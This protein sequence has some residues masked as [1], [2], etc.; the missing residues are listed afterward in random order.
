M[1]TPPAVFRS[2]LRLSYPLAMDLS[3]V[4]PSS[5][6]PLCSIDFALAIA[7]ARCGASLAFT[8]KSI[9]TG[10]SDLSS[11]LLKRITSF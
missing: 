11:L 8:K 9:A 10:F 3:Y 4:R 5:C 1:Y 7:C 2:C 6:L